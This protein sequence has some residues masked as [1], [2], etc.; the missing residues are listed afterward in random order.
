[1][2]LHMVRQSTPSSYTSIDQKPTLAGY[3]YELQLELTP[4]SMFTASPEHLETTSLRCLGLGE[5]SLVRPS[6]QLDAASG[7]V[8]L[9]MTK[10]GQSGPCNERCA[11]SNKLNPLR[12]TL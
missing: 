4:L 11:L 7:M 8:T 3:H 5:A 10:V 1:M 2:Q 12:I 9:W 6:W